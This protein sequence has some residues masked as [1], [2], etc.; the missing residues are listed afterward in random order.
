MPRTL[1]LVRTRIEYEQLEACFPNAIKMK[2]GALDV[3]LKDF[4]ATPNAVM[5]G[6][7]Q[8]CIHGFTLPDDTVIVMGPGFHSAE[9]IQGYAR[10]RNDETL[11]RLDRAFARPPVPQERLVFEGASNEAEALRTLKP[12]Y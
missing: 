10:V 2:A 1:M 11:R 5:I 6:R 8:M 7:G 12:E 3:A 4:R 9:Y